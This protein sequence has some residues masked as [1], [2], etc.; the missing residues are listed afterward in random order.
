MSRNLRSSKSLSV[1]PQ[2]RFFSDLELFG[3][4]R[5]DFHLTADVFL[6]ADMF[7]NFRDCMYDIF[8]SRPM[9]LIFRSD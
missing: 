3:G 8:W 6:L 9:M 1:H 4:L 7:E 2:E 5:F